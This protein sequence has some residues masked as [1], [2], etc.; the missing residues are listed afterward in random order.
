MGLFVILSYGFRAISI[1]NVYGLIPAEIP[2]VSIT[3]DDPAHHN[4]KETPQKNLRKFT[5][6]VVLTTES[7][8]FGDV[9]SFTKG[10]GNVRN[11]YSIPHVD[12]EPQL[13]N[14]LKSMN[15]WG[16]NRHHQLNIKMDDIALF[17]PSGDIPMPI[18]LQVL[19]GL[20]NSGMFKR[21]I[22]GSGLI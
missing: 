18:V 9:D 4:F 3:P 12:G 15:N 13:L 16:K 22:L 17:V 6:V 10:F 7:F 2:V 20:N 14:L 21:V 11:K 5:P 19:A 1:P 8:Y